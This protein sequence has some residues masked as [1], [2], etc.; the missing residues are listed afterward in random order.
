MLSARVYLVVGVKG[1]EGG[2]EA[3]EMEKDVMV[4]QRWCVC[5]GSWTVLI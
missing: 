5:L 2:T 3:G 1:V 4:M